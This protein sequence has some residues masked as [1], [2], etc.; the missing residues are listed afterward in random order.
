MV[1]ESSLP[2]PGGGHELNVYLFL[3]QQLASEVQ[4]KLLIVGKLLGKFLQSEDLAAV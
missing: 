2:P 3:N 4:R 1:A